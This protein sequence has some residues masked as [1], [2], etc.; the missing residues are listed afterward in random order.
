M[1]KFGGSGQRNLGLVWKVLRQQIVKSRAKFLSRLRALAPMTARR[2]NKLQPV[3]PRP[4][5]PRD[6]QRQLAGHIIGKLQNA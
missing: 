2:R 1:L 3:R 6:L 5:Q 4:S